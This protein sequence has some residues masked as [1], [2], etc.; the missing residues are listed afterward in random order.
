[1]HFRNRDPVVWVGSLALWLSGS[2]PEVIRDRE[3][4]VTDC[5]WQKRK[6]LQVQDHQERAPFLVGTYQITV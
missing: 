4:Y 2:L 6:I 5:A 3:S 1:V